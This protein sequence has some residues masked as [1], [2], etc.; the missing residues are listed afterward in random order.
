MSGKQQGQRTKQRHDANGVEQGQ[1]VAWR[2][3]KNVD[4]TAQ[5]KLQYEET[6]HEIDIVEF[7]VL[8]SLSSY[9]LSVFE[10]TRNKVFIA[11]LYDQ[12]AERKWAGYILNVRAASPDEALR[13]L[14]FYHTSLL[15][16]DWGV[17]P[18]KGGEDVW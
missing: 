12:D 6:K 16:G 11:S 8:S 14:A 15:K 3:Y 2:G 1:R 5:E 9:K 10:D 4:I 13:R 17:V 7:I 18:T